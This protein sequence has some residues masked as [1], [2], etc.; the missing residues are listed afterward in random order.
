MKLRK[1][2]NTEIEMGGQDS[3]LDLVSNIVG[4]LIILVMVAGIRAQYSS[5]NI[6]DSSK[7]LAGPAMLADL[8]TKRRELQHKEEVVARTQWSIDEVEIQQEIIAEQL[9]LQSEEYAALFDLMTSIR[10]AIDITAEEKSHTF[11]EKIEYQRQLMEANA[12]LQQIEKAREYFRQIRP[13]ATV[14]ENI[15]TP[16][17]QVVEEKEIHV[18]LLGGRVAHVP[19]DALMMQFRKHIN[20]EQHRYY[21]QKTGA[22]KVGP[23]DNFELEFLLVTHGNPMQGGTWINFQYGQAIPK[24]EPLGEPL[25]EALASPQSEFRRKLALHQKNLY[26][27]TVWLY[28]DSFEE[29]QE[30]KKFLQDNDYAVAARP[31]TMGHPIGISPD[32]TRSSTQ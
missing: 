17:S 26:T 24:F 31:M 20:E 7:P 28:P 11:K 19:L 29:Y 2:K 8:E 13:Q 18:R 16:L 32:G 4:I 15:P 30:L 10:A 21:K 9:F 14:M 3:F 27:V 1:R 25:H 6:A 23:I 22:G 12:K 5:A